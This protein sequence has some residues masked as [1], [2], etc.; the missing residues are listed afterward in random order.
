MGQLALTLQNQSR[1]SFPSDTKK[2]SK[3]CMAI[4]L[5]SGKELQVEKEDEKRQTEEEADNEDQNQTTS[6]ERQER[7]KKAYQNQKLKG[8]AEVQTEKTV[9]KEKEEV[10]VYHPLIP[11]P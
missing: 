8:Q 3:D 4:T 6:E 5:R 7:T 2:N 9:Q 10:R 11:F 1:D